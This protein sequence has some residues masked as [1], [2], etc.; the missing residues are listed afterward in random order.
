MLT[1][2][3]PNEFI[4]SYLRASKCKYVITEY[5]HAKIPPLDARIN[6]HIDAHIDAFPNHF[7]LPI[8]ALILGN[9]PKTT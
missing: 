5:I 9:L 1:E 4:H 6:A 2:S 8:D 7:H 3:A